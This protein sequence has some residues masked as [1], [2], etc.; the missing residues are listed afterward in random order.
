VGAALPI[1]SS[2]AELSDECANQDQDGSVVPDVLRYISTTR[3][4]YPLFNPP[5][6][7][8]LGK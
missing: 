7:T 4:P 8:G 3:R 1:L 2:L 6:V 5:A